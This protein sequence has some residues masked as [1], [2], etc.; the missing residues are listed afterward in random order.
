MPR[1]L[2]NIYRHKGNPAPNEVTCH[3]FTV[4]GIQAQI[5][6]R[7][8]KH[9]NTTHHGENNQPIIKMVPPHKLDLTDKDVNI[10]VIT[11]FCTLIMLSRDMEDTKSTWIKH[12]DEHYNVWDWKYTGLD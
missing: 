9:E 8:K 7:A 1:K 2:R 12:R 6:S 5:T 4:C 10:V 11:A 3:K